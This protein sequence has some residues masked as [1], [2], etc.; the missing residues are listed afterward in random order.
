MGYLIRTVFNRIV[1]PLAFVLFLTPFPAPLLTGSS[2][3]AWACSG[4]CASDSDCSG[5]ACRYC[6]TDFG[7]CSDC[8]EFTE[9]ITCPSACKWEYGECRNVSGTSC[10][11]SLPETKKSYRYL[12][13]VGLVLL[14]AAAGGYF[15]FRRR[16]TASR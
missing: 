3:T 2:S 11:I 12:Y 15:H 8:C 14:S 10:G 4:S 5:N 1:L 13:F 9:F 16:R 6:D 7:V